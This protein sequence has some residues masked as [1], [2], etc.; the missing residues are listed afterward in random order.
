MV[1][2][3]DGG[4]V[5]NQVSPSRAI[6]WPATRA[7]LGYRRLWL[8][9]C[10]LLSA[11]CGPLSVVL[12]NKFDQPGIHGAARAGRFLIL[13]VSLIFV[14]GLMF[15][16]TFLWMNRRRRKA[17]K[18]Y[19][20]TRCQI[21][22][23]TTGRYEWIQL[24]DA[25]QQPISGLILS[26][27]ARDI[28]KLVNHRTPEVWFA[29]D[30]RKYGV[31]SRPGGAD[32]RYAYYSAA[33]KPPEFTFRDPTT[34]EP[35]PSGTEAVS[36]QYEMERI[37]GQVRM[38]QSGDQPEEQ[39]P[40]RYGAINDPDYPSPRK[41]RRTMAFGLDMLIHITAGA[42]VGFAL[43]PEPAKY[44]LLH[45]DWNGLGVIPVLMVLCFI[46]ASLV[47]RVII[48]AIFHTTIGKAIF[49]LVILRPDSGRVPSFG[50][51]LAFW[52]MH[53]YLPL[54]IAGDIFGN[55]GATPDR[56]ENYIPTAVRRR[57]IP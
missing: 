27:W 30:P 6:D 42:A 56:P 54:G 23:I 55:G 51:L 44:A 13:P 28:G 20:W 1:N 19:P 7:A 38:K 47:D 52:L 49:G 43:A 41:L 34:A 35:G 48:Q 16:L 14:F 26:T 18:R 8:W 4:M 5:S 31:V 10:V 40:K 57:D 46:A 24:L 11:A 33:R 37:N 21:N 32:L 15:G 22:Y 3:L 50:R 12:I 39:K 45:R 25:N 53:I 36:A 2:Q 17:L 29:G 9:L